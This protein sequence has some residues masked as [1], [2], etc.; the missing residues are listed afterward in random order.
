MAAAGYTGVAS[1]MNMGVAKAIGGNTSQMILSTAFGGI[2]DS[3]FRKRDVKEEPVHDPV[4]DMRTIVSVLLPA[5]Y[6][7]EISALTPLAFI[8]AVPVYMF[9]GNY[10]PLPLLDI[11]SQPLPGAFARIIGYVIAFNLVDKLTPWNLLRFLIISVVFDL[12]L[13]FLLYFI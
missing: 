12:V 8:T 1:T 10:V 3:L 7:F 2:M 13:R 5:K 9:F 11:L 4:G 6:F